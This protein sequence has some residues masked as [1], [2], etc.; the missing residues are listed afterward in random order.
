M[1]FSGRHTILVILLLLSPVVSLRSQT[2]VDKTATSTISGKVTVG[3]KGLAGV[4]VGLVISEQTRSSARPTRFR[5]T[6]DEE[7]EYRITNVPPGTYDVI[8]AS[9]AYVATE[10]RKSLIVGKNE[11]VENIDIALQLGGVITGK[12]TDADGRPVIEETVY[13]SAATRTQRTVYSRN[14]RTDDRGIY[15]AYGVP[16]GRYTVSAGRDADS[17]F[18]QRRAESANLRTYHPNA[19]DPAAATVIDVRDGSESTNVDITLREPPRTYSASG[20]IIDSET[21]QPVPN[22]KVG[23]QLFRQN[24]STGIGSV[25]ESTKDGEFKL[26]NLA[27]GKYAVYSESTANSEQLSESVEFEVT[28]RDVEGLVIKT[29]RGASVSG[30]VI[31]EGPVDAKAKAILLT[32]RLYVQFVGGN[33]RRPF[34]PATIGPNGSFRLSGLPAGR[35]MLQVEPRGSLRLLRLERDGIVYP[36][37]VELNDQE[38]VTNLRVVVGHANGAVRG[39]IRI[40][41]DLALPPTA[42]LGVFLRRTEDTNPNASVPTVQADARG[43]FLVENLFPGTYEISVGVFNAGPQAQLPRFAPLRQ[44][45]IVTNGAVADVP[46][47]L[48]LVKPPVNQP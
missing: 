13:L 2:A 10:G 24:G 29:S 23:V 21:S 42:R 41:P 47:T 37:G 14:I 38:Q 28:D 4:V 32:S 19:A 26:E 5:S 20:R 39:E 30:V 12:L 31:L 33:F 15:R 16:P 25:A 11:T 1:V 35:I 44:T 45:V 43:H 27:P 7:G 18:V 36:R 8:P 17:A 40:P 3:D 48:Q 9:P 34:L 46:I 6:T 22:T